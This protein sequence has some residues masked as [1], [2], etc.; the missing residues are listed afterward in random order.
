MPDAT[1][2]QATGPQQ[3]RRGSEIPADGFRPLRS[4][5]RPARS[6]LPLVHREA[7][8]DALARTRAPLI[9]VSAPAGAGKSTLLSQFAGADVRPV[10][11]AQLDE[12]DNDPI[13]L[14][15]YLALALDAVSPV[16]EE[17]FPLL[18]ARVPPVDERILPGLA[19]VLARAPAF[20]FVLD[21]AHLITSAECWRILGFIAS[22]LPD[23]C[24]LLIG[25]RTDPPLPL[26]R[27]HAAGR[28]TE[29]RMMDL[30]MTRDEARRLLELYGRSADGP[31]LDDLMRQTEG[32]VTGLCLALLAGDGGSPRE[33]LVSAHGAD[34]RLP[35]T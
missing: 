14:L 22:R 34:V 6:H 15:T 23:G 32:W 30:A 28:L 29:Y 1:S 17:M 5:L 16:D 11:W 25:T 35:A 27:L 21:D 12:G 3:G 7:L 20:L 8:V 24:H 26:A 13:V 18:R 33:L 4:K 2:N 31:A 10:A 19:E 9:L